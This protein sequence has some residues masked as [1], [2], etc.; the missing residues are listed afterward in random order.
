MAPEKDDKF[1]GEASD[2]FSRT[3]SLPNEEAPTTSS[4]D[5]SN[6]RTF[7][8][9]SEVLDQP[10]T[11]G[12]ADSQVIEDALSRSSDEI[13]TS[14]T[15][16]VDSQ[17]LD[18]LKGANPSG[19]SRTEDNSRT[20][21][22]DSQVLDEAANSKTISSQDLGLPPAS[23]KVNQDTLRTYVLDSAESDQDSDSQSFDLR[24]VNLGALAEEDRKVW[25]RVAAEGKSSSRTSAQP[26]SISQS[27]LPG[28]ESNLLLLSRRLHARMENETNPQL[29]PDYE[30]LKVLGR[31][32]MGV[33]YEARQASLDR[34]V[35]IKVIQTI[36]S[37]EKSQFQSTGRLNAAQMLKREQFLSEAVVT[38]DLD[39]PNIVPI[40]DVA[41]TH[42]GNLFY[43]M[44]R[45]EGTPWNE[46]IQDKSVE[47]NLEILMKV[48]DAVAFAHSRGVV[49]RDIKPENVM[50]G[51]F[52]AV[53]LMDWG[54]AVPTPTFR[55]LGTV[56]QVTSLGGSPAYMAPELAIGPIPNITPASDIYLLGAVLYQIVTGRPPHSGSGMSQC[57][58]A[59]VKNIIEPVSVDKQ[60]ELYQIAMKAMATQPVDR[61][62]SV[63]EMQAAI[64]NYRSHTESIHLSKR[65]AQDASRAL[66]TD[67]YADHARAVFG[68]EEALELWNENDEARQGVI[69][70]RLAYAEAAC[71]KEDF[72]LG[73]SLLD[74]EQPEFEPMI[75]LLKQGQT[76]RRL[77]RSRLVAFRR[78]AAAL[79]A[80]ILIGGGGMSWTIFQANRKLTTAH[81]TIREAE[82]KAA[83]LTSQVALKQQ[84]LQVQQEKVV[85]AQNEAA[86]KIRAAEVESTQ[87]IKQAQTVAEMKIAEAAT[88]VESV[89][90][91]LKQAQTQLRETVSKVEVA[92]AAASRA[93]ADAAR[94]EAEAG[95]VNYASA[96]AQARGYLDQNQHGQAIQILKAAQAARAPGQP[97]GWEWQRLW[98]E[99]NRARHEA[100]ATG[101][102]L[103]G[104]DIRFASSGRFALALY[105]DGSLEQ[106]EFTPGQAARHRPFPS[107]TATIATAISPDERLI[108]AAGQ[109]G[110]IRLLDSQSGET[111]QT[112]TLD[113]LMGADGPTIH[114][115]TFLNADLLLA[116]SQDT[117]MRLWNVKT[118]T[119]VGA[120]W[121]LAPVLDLSVVPLGSGQGWLAAAAVSD[122]RNG[123][124]VVWKI[125]PEPGKDQFTRVADMLAHRAPVLSVAFHQD[126]TTVASADQSGRIMTWNWQQI[127]QLD[128]H[129]RI[130]KAVAGLRTGQ[131]SPPPVT[132]QPV[133]EFA[134]A[135]LGNLHRSSAHSGD[136]QLA[137]RDAVRRICFSPDG[138]LLA[139]ASNDLTLKIWNVPSGR[140]RQTLRGQGGPVRS[141]D[142]VP[143]Q[144]RMLMS[145]G[146]GGLLAWDLANSREVV[147]FQEETTPEVNQFT[148]HRDEILSATFD[149]TGTR[150][151]TSSRDHTARVLEIDPVR[152]EI[153]Q[154]ADLR[155]NADSQ[156]S[157]DTRGSLRE[158]G[159][160]ISLSM[161]TTA[162]ES[163]LFVGGADGIIRIW[164]IP[165]AIEIGSISGTG[166]NSS[167][168]LS[169]NGRVVLTGSSDAEARALVWNLDEQG[170]PGTAP[171]WKLQR[172][173]DTVTAFAVSRDGK[174]LFTG[175]R[176]GMGIIWN[177]E[178]GQQ[179][180]S[181]LKQHAGSRLNAAA[182]N[183][184][185][186][187][188]YLAGDNRSVSRVNVET[189]EIIETLRHDGFVTDLALAPGGRQLM[190]LTQI[191]GDSETKTRLLLWN[192]AAPGGESLSY[193]VDEAVNRRSTP[194]DQPDNRNEIRSVRFGRD[195]GTAFS[196]H[197][198]LLARRSYLKVWNVS[199]ENAPQLRR[200]L[201]FPTR[202]A[203]AEVALPGPAGQVFTLN[204]D[205]VFLWDLKSLGHLRSYRPH[206]AVTQAVFSSDGKY[207]A[208]SSRSVKIWDVAAERTVAQMEYPHE[209][210]VLSVAFSPLPNTNQLLTAGDDGNVKLWEWEP[211]TATVHELRRFGEEGTRIRR[212]CF[213]SDGQRILAVGEN[214]FARIWNTDGTGQP[215]GLTDGDRKAD[216]L[217][218]AIST[219]G[220]WVTTGAKDRIA[221]LWR[222][223]DDQT[224]AQLVRRFTGHADEI[225]DI[226]FLSTESPENFRII[227]ASRDTLAR[228]WDPRINQ[229]GDNV[230]SREL[231]VLRGHSLGVTAVDVA[232][233]GR[234]VMSAGLDGE[235]ILWPSRLNP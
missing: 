118:G 109:D 213:S 210:A 18:E 214:G 121:N 200:G 196:I 35:A 2:D 153:R 67:D 108:A 59:A 43:S 102:V 182:F 180:G 34:S 178:T 123:R 38:G 92:Q 222:I 27:G 190:T 146:S 229:M 169:A 64:R 51:E 3:V 83:G 70:S 135:S 206:A 79:L 106:I 221:R 170:H 205:A 1:P 225:S 168:A 202:A 71:Q 117:T 20:F 231:L 173:Q 220:R 156:D 88:Q 11:S 17:I 143:G 207:V 152:Q 111:R 126:G 131:V 44:K 37:E 61:Y 150:I 171:R 101:V 4:P 66:D 189:G 216:Y 104:R 212:V 128:Y 219:D 134:D 12:T 227:S 116:G 85:L 22:M 198:D 7:V 224:S 158:G 234:L 29:L 201:A 184:Q 181:T 185:G 232:D 139:S 235:V 115:L 127:G 90:N 93:A 89:N 80:V 62:L 9:D 233:H 91:N 30:I 119:E 129:D 56:R 32:G 191:P 6:S 50:L 14:R 76:E 188:L 72:D 228:V 162:D 103:D 87:K 16:I 95:Y 41:R 165:R 186:T 10:D 58:L 86:E 197:V 21:V 40:Y 105:D 113:H 82:A 142:F 52:G 57:L 122:L 55:K 84:E 155:D 69:D 65:A 177:A 81:G 60:G 53:M 15:C 75:T 97:L 174:L 46:V 99:A 132:E 179:I 23:G 215:L 159:K 107:H 226:K 45:V 218:C 157:G 49:H 199:T 73:L 94:A 31:G 5:L 133:R 164:N 8:T 217:C 48:A 151:V 208:T 112:L 209:G 130:S 36:P 192:L 148:A 77:R 47:D 154:I 141:V 124:V 163:L 114:T 204:G 33:V 172:H 24:T 183:E 110:A 230:A 140:L 25:E 54:L 19:A 166:L 28:M 176:Q 120:C 175:D 195:A 74:P 96:I 78:V 147:T 42:E 193:S 13:D 203:T 98:Y 138:R 26:G 125:V 39:H 160:F 161:Q 136:S 137:H 144:S 63:Q 68:Y 167:F 187:E 223:S 100:S 145:A 149:P 194:G 211:Q